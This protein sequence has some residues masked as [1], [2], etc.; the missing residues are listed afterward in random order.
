MLSLTCYR[1]QAENAPL[2]GAVGMFPRLAFVSLSNNLMILSLRSMMSEF[3]STCALD[4]LCQK[5]T[6]NTASPASALIGIAIF[7]F[8]G[9][10]Y[11][12]WTLGGGAYSWTQI[13]W[14]LLEVS[15]GSTDMIVLLTLGAQTYFGLDATGFRTSTAFHQV[16]GPMLMVNFTGLRRMGI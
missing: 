16:L 9:F 2:A 3:F 15:I 6:E 4:N 12:L 11:A 7:C 5:H 1:L 13:G 8:L 10:M 14:Y